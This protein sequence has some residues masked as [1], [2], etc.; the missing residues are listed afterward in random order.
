MRA[1]NLFF[2]INLLD[3]QNVTRFKKIFMEN[4]SQKRRSARHFVHNR[5]S[6][7]TAD[8]DSFPVPTFLLQGDERLGRNDVMAKVSGQAGTR[9]ASGAIGYESATKQIARS[10]SYPISEQ[11]P[12]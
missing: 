12:S 8:Q 6:R 7:L 4:T 2:S 9:N 1:S 10:V 11:H 3:A 5:Y